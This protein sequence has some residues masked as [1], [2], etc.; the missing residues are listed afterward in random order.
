MAWEQDSK[1]RWTSRCDVCGARLTGG[2]CAWRSLPAQ[3][4]VNTCGGGECHA[5][6]R[7]R[8]PFV[9]LERWARRVPTQLVLNLSAQMPMREVA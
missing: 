6:G 5:E 9:S 1:G 8:W 7:R 4:D 3:H 2:G